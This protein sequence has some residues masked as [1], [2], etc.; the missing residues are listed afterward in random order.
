[1]EYIDI[2]G[3]LAGLLTSGAMLPQLIK[4]IREKNQKVYL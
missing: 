2:L 4:V 1:M 3:G